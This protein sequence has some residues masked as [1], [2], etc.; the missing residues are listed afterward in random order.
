M[1]LTTSKAFGNMATRRSAGGD[2]GDE[3]PELRRPSAELSAQLALRIAEGKALLESV[4][5]D[6]RPDEDS[7]RAHRDSFRTWDEYN[8]TLLKQSFTTNAIADEYERGVGAAFMKPPPL[9][10]RFEFLRD[11]IVAQVRK[12]DSILKRVDGGL[13]GP[14]P[15][16]MIGAGPYAGPSPALAPSLRPAGQRVFL[17]HGHDGERKLEVAR[18][19]ERVT[20]QEPIILHMQPNSGRTI[21][22]K[23]EQHASEA[24]FA[25][26]LLTADD[27]GRA[28]DGEDR[29]RARQ[30]VVFEF[31][32]FIGS[33]GRDRVAAL[34]ERGVE[35]PSD[36]DGLL[37]TSLEGNWQVDLGRELKRAD[38]D[39]NLSR[40]I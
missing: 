27:L 20:G 18:Y 24:G 16:P 5:G 38:I 4:L 14:G 3:R 39:V 9:S 11:D 21:I 17:V 35:Q 12:V 33:L 34:H 6:Y 1:A 28:K 37:Y 30:N 22:E 25:V 19:L 40:L 29:P 36:I 23:F 10:K 26:I 2:G 13:F 7:Y 32:F 8:V 15:T 31:G